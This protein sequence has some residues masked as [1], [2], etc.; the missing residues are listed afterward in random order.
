MPVNTLEIGVKR[1]RKRKRKHH[2]RLVRGRDH[3]RIGDERRAYR[4]KERKTDR[5]TETG[6][7]TSIQRACI[8]AWL[9]YLFSFYILLLAT[10]V[11]FQRSGKEW[12]VS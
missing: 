5:E 7:A 2:G 3:G 4:E 12:N 1:K 6:G 9:Q 11:I 10:P 8:L